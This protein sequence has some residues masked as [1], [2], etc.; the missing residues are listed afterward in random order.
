MHCDSEN[1][2][3]FG[4]GNDLHISG[5]ANRNKDSYNYLFSFS[6]PPGKETTFFT[7]AENFIVSNYEVFGLGE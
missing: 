4:C 3:T 6:C 2:P 5:N 1:G 7:G